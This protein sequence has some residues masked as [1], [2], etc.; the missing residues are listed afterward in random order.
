MEF[1]F[2]TFFDEMSYYPLIIMLCVEKK[3][4]KRFLILDIYAGVFVD[5]IAK[6]TVLNF[7]QD[8]LLGS[9]EKQKSKLQLCAHWGMN[10]L[11]ISSMPS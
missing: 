9:R 11:G 7:S 8:N 1:A 5:F 2:L 6:I 10:G 4:K 3:N